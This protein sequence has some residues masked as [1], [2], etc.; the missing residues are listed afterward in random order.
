MKENR[1]SERY[2]QENKSKQLKFFYVNLTI[3]D[4]L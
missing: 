3:L 1:G 2:P 4:I